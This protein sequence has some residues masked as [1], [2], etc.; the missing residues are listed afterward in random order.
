MKVNDV[1]TNREIRLMKQLGIMQLKA[2][3]Y[4]DDYTDIISF[5]FEG[6][7]IANP[8]VEESDYAEIDPVEY[9]GKVFLNSDFM[10]E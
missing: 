1:L 9:Y 7:T 4:E 3:E 2:L 8:F 10:K 6:M 5:Q